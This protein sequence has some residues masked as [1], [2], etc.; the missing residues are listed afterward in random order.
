[1]AINTGGFRLSQMPRT[2]VDFRVNPVD[3]RGLGQ[4]LSSF[5]KQV[6]DQKLKEKEVERQGNIRLAAF[7]DKEALGKLDESDK[8]YVAAMKEEIDANRTRLRLAEMQA[9]AA[10]A[11]SGSAKRA[12]DYRYTNDFREGTV[13]RLTPTVRLD[14]TGKVIGP[15]QVPEGGNLPQRG[16][17]LDWS[18]GPDV[19][20]DAERNVQKFR[21]EDLTNEAKLKDA[22]LSL[23]TR[24]R[25]QIVDSLVTQVQ[26]KDGNMVN[27]E[28]LEG[29]D[30]SVASEVEKKSRIMDNEIKLSDLRVADAGEGLTAK[31][32]ANKEK[33]EAQSI[34]DAFDLIEAGKANVEQYQNKEWGYKLKRR[35]DLKKFDDR[36]EI[37]DK[38]PF[39]ILYD[40]YERKMVDRRQ[41][42]ERELLLDSVDPKLRDAMNERLVSMIGA[43]RQS[44]RKIGAT[45]FEVTESQ[46]KAIDNFSLMIDGKLDP[47]EGW[48]R[49]G[50]LDSIF[51][52]R[53]SEKEKENAKLKFARI[54]MTS[55]P[56]MV[57]NMDFSVGKLVDSE[58]AT[59]RIL[60]DPNTGEPILDEQGN[61]KYD[62]SEDAR[63]IAEVFDGY[64]GKGSA[65]FFLNV[66]KLED[67]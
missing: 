40:K 57:Q 13:K 4:G 37:Q 34:D 46:G 6:G 21:L 25:T 18:V 56:K 5:G 61:P 45:E 39:T 49:I 8:G 26:W 17:M 42:T 51:S 33:L 24:E 27:P 55:D 16:K 9:E 60:R 54:V 47:G 62:N 64:F 3:L 67:K 14:E 66:Y 36:Y 32:I 31:E 2:E 23:A 12:S 43:E 29:V 59:R 52:G 30:E 65:D 38:G 20:Q 44:K 58:Y 10:V 35:V 19:R 7:G 41:K 15:Y 63:S 22:Q 53:L 48:K 11:A 28:V 50:L 1:M